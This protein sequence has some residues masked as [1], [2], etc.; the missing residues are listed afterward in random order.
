MQY[1]KVTQINIGIFSS[2]CPE[3]VDIAERP[4][5]DWFRYFKIDN[6]FSLPYNIIVR[7]I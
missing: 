5:S 3:R 4:V 7:K 2:D 1:E 6:I